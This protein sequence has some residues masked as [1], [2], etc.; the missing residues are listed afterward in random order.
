MNIDELS[1][2]AIVANMQYHKALAE[3]AMKEAEFHTERAK[4][5]DEELKRR[6]K[7]VVQ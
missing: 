5:Y 6:T 3:R 2:E 7:N 1:E 4:V